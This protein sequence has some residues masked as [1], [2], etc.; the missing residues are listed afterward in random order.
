PRFPQP[1]FRFSLRDG[2]L[3]KPTI[4]VAGNRVVKAAAVSEAGTGVE[5]AYQYCERIAREHYE[6]FPVASTVLPA[7]MRPHVAAVYAFA[8]RADD[9]ADEPGPDVDE[10][11]RLL[12]S[13]EQRLDRGVPNSA[14]SGDDLIFVALEHT[15]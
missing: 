4:R 10:R 14:A 3:G 7:A 12:D 5:A 11:L 6:N 13:W 2:A 8:R 15:I 9:F 1:S